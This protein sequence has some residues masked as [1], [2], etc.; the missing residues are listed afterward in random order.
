[1]PGEPWH[2]RR[3]D[4]EQIIALAQRQHVLGGYVTFDELAVDHGGMARAQ[5]RR[6]AEAL[7]DRAHIGL[8]VIIDLETVAFQMAD[9][10]FAAAAVG[11]AVYVDGDQLGR[12]GQAGGQQG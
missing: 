1:M 10:L 9:P 12:L 2:A 3:G 11:V 7:F 8:N 4:T 6:D 5:A